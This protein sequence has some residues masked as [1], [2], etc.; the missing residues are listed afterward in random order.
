MHCNAFKFLYP[1]F[2]MCMASIEEIVFIL[3][4]SFGYAALFGIVFAESGLFFGFFLPGDSLLFT[5]GLLAS[6]G[7]FDIKIVLAGVAVAAILGDQAGY[8][9]GH[10]FGRAFFTKKD[11]LFRNPD[12]ITKAEEF[13]KKHG[14]KTIIIARFVPA[15]RT[16]APIV[17][18]I[19]RME[20]GQF[21]SYNIIGGVL[22]TIAFV[23]GGYFAGNFFPQAKDYL[24]IILPAIIIASL[25]P[26][27]ISFLKEQKK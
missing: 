2:W 25:V 16:F 7:F 9:M 17:A 4:Y 15:A 13:Y 23:G 8:W 11:S 26:I 19:G 12:H 5:A 10:K 22:W 27:A 3:L 6:Q 24:W 21:V 1:D 18:G 20:Y 14:K